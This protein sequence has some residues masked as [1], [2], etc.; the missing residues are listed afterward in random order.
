MTIQ[1]EIEKYLQ[2]LQEDAKL[3]KVTP[4]QRLWAGY[5]KV[6]AAETLISGVVHH[7][8][9]KYV[10]VPEAKADGSEGFLRKVRS[11]Q[12]EGQFY[13]QV[14][15]GVTGL[16]QQRKA[17][18]ADV[19]WI[20]MEPQRYSFV[21]VLSDLK[22][23][24]PVCKA[25]LGLDESRA[26]LRWL[27]GFH[28]TFWGEK[29]KEVWEQGSYW[30]LG[31][32]RDE[33]DQMPVSG[34]FAALKDKAEEID[35]RIKSSKFLTVIHGDFKSANMFFGEASGDE[36]ECCAFDFQYVG[37][38]LGM[39]DVVKLFVSSLSAE[40]LS[41]HEDELRLLWY[42]HECL[43]EYI[44]EEYPFQQLCKDYELCL[45]DYYRFLLG[46]SLW[47]HNL[48]FATKRVREI[49]NTQNWL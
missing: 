15:P 27:A 7:W 36:M 22:R 49:M 35:E 20:F 31:T 44:P 26:A 8:V 37:V 5:G 48:D 46:W 9:V 10:S 12:V 40:I 39:R 34:E 32:R 29:P 28:G 43:S 14:V 41:T 4:I 18:I 17:W 21:F 19:C 33:Y 47:G 30:Y 23:A 2:T 24:F 11:Y 25:V 45:L 38:S 6:Y 16:L 1:R 3:C 13:Q 42:Y